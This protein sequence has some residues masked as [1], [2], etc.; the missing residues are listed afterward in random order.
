MPLKRGSWKKK[1]K[2][3]ILAYQ[4]R[5]RIRYL[6]T[7]SGFGYGLPTLLFLLVILALYYL[8]DGPSVLIEVFY[9]MRRCDWLK[10]CAGWFCAPFK[11]FKDP[12]QY[13]WGVNLF[14]FSQEDFHEHREKLNNMTNLSAGRLPESFQ[15]HEK[16]MAIVLKFFLGKFSFSLAVWKE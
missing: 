3:L 9:E 5:I 12:A 7:D 2:T 10:F 8:L 1:L 13:C 4:L 16:L 14:L 11:W 15:R 6:K